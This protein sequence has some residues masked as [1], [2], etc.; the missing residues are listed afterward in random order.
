MESLRLIA[1]LPCY[2]LDDIAKNLDEPTCREFHTA[3]TALW[4]PGILSRSAVLPEWKRADQSSL[5]LE[6]ALIVCPDSAKKDLDQ[7]LTERLE[8]HG[9]VVV[10]AG[11]DRELLVD[12]ILQI[13]ESVESKVSKSLVLPE[14]T[15]DEPT[16]S[17]LFGQL[18][19]SVSIDDF[20]SFGFAFLLVQA[21][22]RK[23]HYS[24]NL[25]LV[26]LADQVQSAAQAYLAGE[27]ADA[28]RWLQSCYD[29][30]SQERDRYFNQSAYL[31]DLTLLANSTLGQSLTDQL[32]H[33]QPQ[34]LLG[35]STLLTQFQHGNPTA[36]EKLLARLSMQQASLVGGLDRDRLHPWHPLGTLQRDLIRGQSAYRNLQIEPPRVYAQFGAGMS[37]EMPT[38]LKSMGYIGAILHAFSDG[39]YPVTS[40]AKI[41]WEATDT[42]TLDAINSGVLDA[43]SCR[44]MF[45][46]IN[47]LAKQFDHHQV[48]TLVCAHWP[49]KTSVAYRDFLNAA[50]RTNAFG[51]WSTLENYF[52]TTGYVYSNQNF[53]SA[54]FQFD[55]P[56]SSAQYFRH[57]QSL[58]L[59][60]VRNT[61]LESTLSLTCLIEQVAIAMKCSDDQIENLRSIHTQLEEW[62][63]TS[64]DITREPSDAQVKCQSEC[65]AA[66]ADFRSKLGS[67]LAAI[68]PRKK[69]VS[70]D[71]PG[72]LVINPYSGARRVNVVELNGAYAK[73]EDNRVYDAYPTGA[74]SHVIV[75]VPPMGVVQL[76]P[77]SVSEGTGSHRKAGPNLASKGLLLANEFIECQVDPAK[78]YLRS[79]MLAKKRGGRLSGLPAIVVHNPSGKSIPT[80]STIRNAQSRIVENTPMQA[81]IESVGE[82]VSDQSLLATF[83]L[84]FHMCRGARNVDLRLRMKLAEPSRGD[85]SI[86]QGAPVWRTAWPSQAADL[87]TWRQ[88][89]KTKLKRTTFFAPE[90]IEIDDAEHRIFLAFR[91]LSVHRRIESTFLDTLLP[92]NEIGEVDQVWSIGVDWPRPF[93]TFL[94]LLDEPWLISDSGA[95]LLNGSS[96]WFAQANQPNVRLELRGRTDDKLRILFHET[97]GR[98][99]KA[100]LSF[101]RDANSAARVEHSGNCIEELEVENGQVLILAKPHEISFLDVNLGGS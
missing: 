51:Q 78:G 92:V 95:P 9:C 62:L 11:E 87:A 31:I 101:F 25:D 90:L 54:D 12:G 72:Y 91:G 20:Y 96:L 1:V 69:Q 13:L 34:N 41:S 43:A 29:L 75:D 52:E 82:L 24:S 44:S 19:T 71:K 32:D 40:Q 61:R 68:L 53:T 18:K 81:T 89:T 49:M 38:H 79:I 46:A 93:Q 21:L 30:L 57:S 56:N 2:S 27:A 3:W 22:T 94:E 70:P 59:Q 86:W 55:L 63:E 6:K 37:I 14:S 98:E 36:W 84:S 88:G 10:E 50:R 23:V 33:P 97:Q 83:E 85:S 28:E 77:R 8:L 48:P 15:P 7:P 73:T 76:Q 80:Y 16:S 100:K 64:D 42:T 4:H 67:F 17:D 39:R 26:V 99:V 65:L 58:Q 60:L 74:Q 66:V 47:E 45:N 35:T 5:D